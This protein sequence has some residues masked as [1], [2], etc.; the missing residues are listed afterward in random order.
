MP[1]ARVQE[2]RRAR[3]ACH[4]RRQR[5]SSPPTSCR[6][7]PIVTDLGDDQSQPSA[8]ALTNEPL[9]QGEPMLAVAAVDELTAAEA[10]ERIDVKCEAAAVRRSI[11][12]RACGPAGPNA[13]LDGNIWATPKRPA[14]AGRSRRR[15]IEDPEVDRG[16]DFAECAARAAADGQDAG[17][18]GVRR[19]RS[20]LQDAALVLDE[21]FVDAEHQPPAARDRAR[22]WR[23]G[24][25][26]SCT[27]T[28]RRR[29]SC[30]PSIR[31][32]RWLALDPKDIVVI[33]EYTGGG[34]GSKG[35]RRDHRRSIPALLSKKAGAPVMM[36]ISRETEHYIGGARTG[37][38]RAREGRVREGRPHHRARHVRR[39]RQRTVRADGRHAHRPGACVSLLYQPPAMRWRGVAVLTNTPPR[40]RAES[41]RAG[42][43]ASPIMEPIVTKAARKLG[44][45]QVAIRRVNS[46]EG[47]ALFGPANPRGERGVR[48]ERVREGGARSRR[49][50]VQV[51]R[52][53]GAAAAS[54]RAR[55]CAASASRWARSSPARS[56]TTA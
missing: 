46:P 53:Q 33:S 17:R 35:D 23:T 16:R 24:R 10:I 5:Q 2:H 3:G 28:A 56:A 51:G 48:H 18:M 55:R 44:L 42:C 13:R 12:S 37:D 8:K 1:H 15:A 49:R 41:A 52:A 11:R 32:S 34:F 38:D 22:R 45:D 50:A 21:T 39:R 19:S 30:R 14:R 47:K 29:A 36:R 25:T 4:A 26:A 9:Y 7:Q 31:V 54:A 6:R 40:R 43:R 27:C 20:R